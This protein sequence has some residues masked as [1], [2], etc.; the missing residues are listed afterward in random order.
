[1]ILTGN[2]GGMEGV[3]K[4]MEKLQKQMDEIRKQAEKL[5]ENPSND[6]FSALILSCFDRDQNV[7]GSW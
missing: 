7:L 5:R 2:F 4:S 1:M 6:L 3:Q